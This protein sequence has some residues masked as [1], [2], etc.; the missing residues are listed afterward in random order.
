MGLSINS[1]YTCDACGAPQTQTV[2]RKPE[3]WLNM[4]V[5]GL[6]GPVG[7][8]DKY[9]CSKACLARCMRKLADEVDPPSKANSI[10][11]GGP[12]R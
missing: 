6:P 12:Y 9:A 3:G 8:Y 11:S 7:K 5:Y 10:P 4:A 1:V 2:D